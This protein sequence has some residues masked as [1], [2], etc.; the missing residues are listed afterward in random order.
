MD[1]LNHK[2]SQISGLKMRAQ[3]KPGYYKALY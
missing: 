2:V 1:K 3:L